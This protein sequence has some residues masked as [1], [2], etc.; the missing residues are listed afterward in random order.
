MSGSMANLPRCGAAD[1]MLPL[2]IVVLCFKTLLRKGGPV[3]WPGGDR[4]QWIDRPRGPHIRPVV[5][6]GSAIGEEKTSEGKTACAKTSSGLVGSP[7]ARPRRR[8]TSAPDHGVSASICSN[9][10][11]SPQVN[12]SNRSL[13]SNIRGTPTGSAYRRLLVPVRAPAAA[14]AACSAGAAPGEHHKPRL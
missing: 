8:S 3:H 1:R 4:R 11:T 7:T 6:R 9:R 5:I 10:N 14:Q 12:F 2:V 13:I